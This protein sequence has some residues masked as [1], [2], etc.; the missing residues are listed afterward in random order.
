V[1]SKEAAVQVA[2]ETVVDLLRAVMDVSEPVESTAT[3]VAG[4]TSCHRPN[5]TRGVFDARM[6]Q[7]NSALVQDDVA[8]ANAIQSQQLLRTARVARYDV[9]KIA[10]FVADAA[11]R[12]SVGKGGA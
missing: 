12:V 10:R 4:A 9:C 8:G 5:Q 1:D 6:T 7:R 11:C 2:N 3:G